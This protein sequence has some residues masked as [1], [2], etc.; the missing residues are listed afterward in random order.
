MEIFCYALSASD[1][2]EWR[3]RI[4]MEAEHFLDVSAWSVPDIAGKMSADGIHIGVNLNGYTKVTV[5]ASTFLFALSPCTAARTG[6]LWL[7]LCRSML[8]SSMHAYCCS[9]L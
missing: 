5:A 7:L 6:Y 4:E 3:Q 2:S 1:N 9:C 8:V